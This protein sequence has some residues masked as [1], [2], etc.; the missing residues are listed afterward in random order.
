MNEYGPMLLT[1]I[2]LEPKM[3]NLCHQYRAKPTC[4]SVQSDLALYCWM[5]NYKLVSLKMTM[6]SSKNGRWIIPL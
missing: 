4:T 3:F 5:A 2:L 6:D 1:L